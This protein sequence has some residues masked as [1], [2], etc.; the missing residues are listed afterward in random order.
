MLAWITIVYI[1]FNTLPNS[2]PSNLS[3]SFLPHAPLIRHSEHPSKS[4][5]SRTASSSDRTSCTSLSPN[6]CT[7]IHTVSP[8]FPLAP[9]QVLL[10]PQWTPTPHLIDDLLLRSLHSLSSVVMLVGNV[11]M[12]NCCRQ[13]LKWHATASHCDPGFYHTCQLVLLILLYIMLAWIIIVYT[14]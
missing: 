7:D 1:H 8:N 4:Y 3:G 11:T 5:N 10:A 13:G 9:Q 14:L 12:L 2:C 6:T